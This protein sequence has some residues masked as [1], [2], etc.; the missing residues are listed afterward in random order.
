MHEKPSCWNWWWNLTTFMNLFY[1]HTHCIFPLSMINFPTS[2]PWSI[3]HIIE[4][5]A[6]ELTYFSKKC[7]SEMIQTRGK[8][9]SLFSTCINFNDYL[10]RYQGIILF[11]KW[12]D[13]GG[14]RWQITYSTSSKNNFLQF[15]LSQTFGVVLGP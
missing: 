8:L 11:Y 9:I 3:S 13:P 2:S 12:Y 14:Y 10:I 4:Y 1:W 6:L 15:F 7:L 5:L